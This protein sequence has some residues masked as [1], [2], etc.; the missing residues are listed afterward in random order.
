M[1]A[2]MVGTCTGVDR[3]AYPIYED[4]FRDFFL[5]K[6]ELKALMLTYDG[7]LA[8]ARRLLESSHSG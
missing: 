4:I 3:L 1:V 7:Y 8:G 6:D 5:A 2:M